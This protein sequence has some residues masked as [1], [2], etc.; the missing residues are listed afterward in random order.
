MIRR[1]LV[2]LIVLIPWTV[3]LI[4]CE[5]PV[6]ERYVVAKVED[7]SLTI[8]ELMAEMPALG[9]QLAFTLQPGPMPLSQVKKNP[10][11]IR[12]IHIDFK[13]SLPKFATRILGLRI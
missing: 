10:A 2:C 4:S 7:E 11:A 13:D 5:K 9:I 3:F 1:K 12:R 8:Q 6:D